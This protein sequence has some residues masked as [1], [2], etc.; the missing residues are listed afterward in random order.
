MDEKVLDFLKHSIRFKGSLE[1]HVMKNKIIECVAD[2]L[3][4]SI[5]QIVTLSKDLELL[6]LIANIIEN[7]VCKKHKVDKKELVLEIVK[8]LFPLLS[9]QDLA[10]ISDNIEMLHF[11]KLIKKVPFWKKVRRYIFDSKKK[12]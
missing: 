2:Q 3:S 8:K 11:N 12:D 7:I 5:P 4:K 6:K 9:E 1:K 10:V